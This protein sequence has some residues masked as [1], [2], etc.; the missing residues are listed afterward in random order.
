MD[1]NSVKENIRKIRRASGLSQ[2]DMADRLGLSRTAYN[3]LEQGDTKLI[4][5][6]V[7]QIAEI[8]NTTSEEL[9]LGYKPFRKDSGKL[10]DIHAEFEAEKAE[11]LGRHTAEI[12]K[13]QKQIET[14]TEYVEILK[15]SNRTKDEIISMLKKKLSDQNQ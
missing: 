1:N 6:K 14:L 5:G 7:E 15:D 8:F 13:L 9:V 2:S 12:A 11:I 10:K 4:N 3:N